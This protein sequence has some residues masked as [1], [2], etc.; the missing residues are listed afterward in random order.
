[1]GI[2]RSSRMDPTPPPPRAVIRATQ[3]LLAPWRWL[4]KPRFYGMGNVPTDRPVLLVG[5]HTLMGMLDVPLMMIG[6]WERRGLWP[7]PLGD[8]AHFAIPGWREL[9]AFFGTVEGTRQNCRALMRAGQSILVF[10]GGAREVFKR[11]GEQYRLRWSYRMGFARL[12][13]EHGFPI[14]PFAAVGA[15]DCYRIVLDAG[16][17][18]RLLPPVRWIPRS[19]EMPPLVR[20]VGPTVIPRPQRFYFYFAPPIETAHLCGRERDD[21][22]VFA[23]REQVRDAIEA[24][25]E[26]LLSERRRDP[27]RRLIPRMT[28][29]RRGRSS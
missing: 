8:H 29:A 15:D 3:A 11:K 22:A 13:V 1:V 14:V 10:P 25:L 21:A 19:D 12:A 24:G 28:A 6:L 20:G 23:V 26:F 4:T 9:V 27:K 5:N 18:R 17:V 2:I 16:E 7:R